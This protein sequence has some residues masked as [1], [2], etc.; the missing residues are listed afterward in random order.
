MHPISRWHRAVTAGA[1]AGVSVVALGLPA[2]SQTPGG[3]G[4]AMTLLPV[5]REGDHQFV[6]TPR[7]FKV[8][9]PGIG[10]ARDAKQIAVYQD[11]QQNFWY[12]NKHGEPTQVKP[13]VM[14]SVFAQIQ[15][16]GGTVPGGAPGGARPPGVAA[17]GGY[18]PQGAY[19]SGAYPAG[20][21]PPAGYAQPPSQQTTIIE[22]PSSSGSNGN[23]MAGALLGT[24]GAFAG[25]ATGAALVNSGSNNYYAHPYGGVP[26]GQPVYRAPASG[27]HNNG[28]SYY[29]NNGGQKQ[30]IETNKTNAGMF[31]QFD[32]QGNWKD[33]DQWDKAR[34]GGRR[35]RR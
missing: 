21:Y 2:L 18:P 26:Y 22:Q 19:P 5:V 8:Q 1:V 31:K 28:N 30:N 25:A 4:L 23:A 32:Q 9:V 17:Q 10:I 35:R 20:T 14:Q 34:R 24:A 13:E 33:R 16:Q 7:G 15:H 29:Y 27:A 12:I 6:I 11:P 3:E